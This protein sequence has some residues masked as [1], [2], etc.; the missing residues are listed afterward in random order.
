MIEKP[1]AQTQTS[2]RQCCN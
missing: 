1:R 2:L